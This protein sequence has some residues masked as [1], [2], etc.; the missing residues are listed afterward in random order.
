[1]GNDPGLKPKVVPMTRD[2][3][4]PSIPSEPP[5]IEQIRS[6]QK[7]VGELLWTVTR[8]RP[9]LMFTVAKV[10]ALVTKEGEE[11]IL[12]VA[13]CDSQAAVNLEL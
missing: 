4:V 9:D 12:K 11:G 10:S 13:W 7:E 8:T 1:M 2:Q 5:T 3:C 6:A